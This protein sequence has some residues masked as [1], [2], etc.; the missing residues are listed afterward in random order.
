ME[1]AKPNQIQKSG[2]NFSGSIQ[3]TTTSDLLAAQPIRNQIT[4]FGRNNV[5]MEIATAVNKCCRALDIKLDNYTLQILIE[6]I[7]DKYSYDSIED[8]QQ[9]LKKGRQGNYGPTYN[10]L[11]MVIITAWMSKHLDEKGRAKEQA[12]AQQRAAEARPIE[13]DKNLSPKGLEAIQKIKEMTKTGPQQYKPSAKEL[14]LFKHALRTF[15]DQELQQAQIDWS[16]R[17]RPQH[18]QLIEAELISRSE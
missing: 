4:K 14:N 7:V 2:T 17:Q 16:K 18:V 5:L 3:I 1:K 9:C 10:K 15:T 13:G 12:L 6:D 11:N 8:I